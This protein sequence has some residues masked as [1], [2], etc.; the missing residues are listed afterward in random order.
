MTRTRTTRP[1]IGLVEMM[2]AMA[3]TLGIMLILAESFKMALDFVRSAN[4]TGSMVTQLNGAGLVL[5]N[6]LTAEH[7][8]PEDDKPGRGVKL[9]D[10]RLDWRGG[11]PGWSTPVGGF[12][13][14]ESPVPAPG[15]EQTDG[16]GF[17]IHWPAK[18]HALHFTSVMR[19]GIDQNLFTVIANNGVTYTSPAAEIAYYLVKTG[20]TG[21]PAA[22]DLHSLIRRYRLV[23]LTS[24]D[25][26]ALNPA[27]GDTEV[28]STDS[29]GKVHTLATIAKN[30]PAIPATFSGARF[31][32]DV[33]VSNVLSFEVL[34]DWTPHPSLA[35]SRLGPRPYGGDPVPALVAAW[36]PDRRP[37]YPTAASPNPNSDAPVDYLCIAGSGGSGPDSGVFDTTTAE[38]SV[39]IKTI[40]IMIRVYDPKLKSA[41]S[42]TWKFAM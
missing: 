27:A 21:G 38:R 1:A 9:S 2:V 12:F 14:I 29:T 31:G 6:D 34:A 30:R 39:R 13:R 11:S 36:A 23:A 3:L 7:F 19:G 16:E 4:S 35:G 28:I 33:V 20:S 41:R 42:N 15:S 17:G 18:N 5:T 22:Q 10:Q 8:L 40:Q 26:V 32:E 25:L 37:N 24:D